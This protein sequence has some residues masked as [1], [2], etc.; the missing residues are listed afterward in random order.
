[1]AEIS[2]Q[3]VN[4]PSN[5]D[6]FRGMALASQ[7]LD[8]AGASFD[9]AGKTF[10]DANQTSMNQQDDVRTAAIKSIMSGVSTPEQLA[11]ARGQIDGLTAGMFNQDKVG[12]IYD[13]LIPAMKYNAASAVATQGSNQT[14]NEAAVTNPINLAGV[15]KQAGIDAKYLPTKYDQIDKETS[16]NLSKSGTIVQAVTD[17]LP[18]TNR[19]IHTVANNG[20]VLG[21]G[22]AD[23]ISRGLMDNLINKGLV[24][25]NGLRQGFIDGSVTSDALGRVEQNVIPLQKIESTKYS[26]G[27]QTQQDAAEAGKDLED[28]K[29]SILPES[30]SIARDAAKNILNAG[31]GRNRI[32]AYNADPLTIDS[33]IGGLKA[34]AGLG[35]AETKQH[36]KEALVGADNANST[37]QLARAAAI[38]AKKEHL[39][40]TW[41]GPDI[42]ADILKNSPGADPVNISKS[43]SA[44]SEIVGDLAQ[45]YP[46][47]DLSAI[48]R[49]EAARI[50]SAKGGL[51]DTF[52]AD[53]WFK[54]IR[55]N[56]HDELKLYITSDEF[57]N[58]QEA[59]KTENAIL[60]QNIKDTNDNY[61]QGRQEQP[62][63]VSETVKSDPPKDTPVSATIPEAPKVKKA[64]TPAEEKTPKQT[65][66]EYMKNFMTPTE[67]IT[68]SIGGI[69]K[70]VP[71]PSL[72]ES[73][74]RRHFWSPERVAE[75][76]YREKFGSQK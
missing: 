13:S 48:S 76:Q 75:A 21:Q 38:N 50:I 68:V 74:Y 22:E 62:K 47:K 72:Y 42:G 29:H 23:I 32:D 52:G 49:T 60:D 18:V 44:F 41:N 57:N 6:V 54:D 63:P 65:K 40:D 43:M 61:N 12:G 51:T 24:S 73:D 55:K 34:S 27:L 5:A 8:R 15:I 33:N 67:P 7:G 64:T 35:G 37:N 16:N 10:T 25:Q 56:L 30:L 46:E 45:K 28:Y 2:W 69:H 58:R 39:N 26:T 53:F 9:S 70:K 66:E 19:T 36:T 71:G 31:I 4:A 3:N 14:E 20:A 59:R 17:T 11:V 1:M